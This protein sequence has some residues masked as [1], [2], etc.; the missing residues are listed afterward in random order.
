MREAIYWYIEN[1]K[2]EIFNWEIE[3]DESYFWPSRIKGKKWRWA[4]K[5]IKVIGILKRNGKVYTEII[6]DCKAKTLLKIIRW[7]VSKD[8]I[9]NTDWWKWYDWLIDL[10]YQKHYRV[11]HW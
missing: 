3:I 7:K 11:N 6:P 4:F 5:K 10:G 2:R 8:S 9:I 1:E